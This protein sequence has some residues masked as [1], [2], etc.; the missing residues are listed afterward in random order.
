M[1][2]TY[3]SAASDAATTLTMPS[4]QEGDLLV[5]FAYNDV[6]GSSTVPTVPSGWIVRISVGNAGRSFVVAWR[7][8]DSG[9]VASGTWTNATHVGCAVYR[10]NAALYLSPGHTNF[11]Q[12][13]GAT[14]LTYPALDPNFRFSKVPDSWVVGFCGT[15]IDTTAETPPTGMTNRTSAVGTGEIGIHDTN[16]ALAWAAGVNVACSSTRFAGVTLEV[17]ETD[18][19]LATGGAA[20]QLVGGGGLV[21]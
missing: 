1:A 7:T 11:F 12:N 8:A 5:A 6:S 20:F 16:G 3:V 18:I 9:S 21:Y 4:H 2:V 14:N 19:E 15:E 13:A 17:F 10:S